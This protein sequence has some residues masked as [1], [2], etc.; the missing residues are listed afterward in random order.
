MRLNESGGFSHDFS[1]SVSISGNVAFIGAPGGDGQV[2]DSGAVYVYTHDGISWI[3]EEKIN[4]SDGEENDMFGQSISYNGNVILIGVPKDD[5]AGSGSGSAY[6]FRYD[7]FEWIE[8]EKL[9]A[10]DGVEGDR[11]GSS[12]S[13]YDG[14]AVIGAPFSDDNGHYS[15]SSYFFRYDGGSW[16]QGIKL[17]ASDGSGGAQFGQPVLASD[18]FALIGAT[19][20]DDDTGSVY[21]FDIRPPDDCNENDILDVCDIRYEC[22]EDINGNNIPD[23]C[24]CLGDLTGD[25]QVNIDDIFA[26]LGLWGSC[27]DPCPPYCKGDLTEDCTVNIDDIFV[28]LGMWGPCE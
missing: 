17:Q 6:V 20:T 3:E 28:I 10:S 16:G 14:E 18:D 2:S 21:V 4:A 15:G 13:L 11:F 22:S 24:E 9:L 23:E 7:G 5:D 12:V 1:T 19:G 8:E 27:P 25:D 26:V